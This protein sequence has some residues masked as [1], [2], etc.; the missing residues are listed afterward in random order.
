MFSKL[1]LYSLQF[2]GGLT[3]G[4]R[5]VVKTIAESM[6]C[7]AEAFNVQIILNLIVTLYKNDVLET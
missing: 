2:Q 3:S 7:S 1:T 6:Q 5:P 4:R